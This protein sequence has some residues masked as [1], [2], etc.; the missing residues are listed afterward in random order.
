[1]PERISTRTYST[2]DVQGKDSWIKLRG[3]TL[4]EAINIRQE[5]EERAGF[6]FRLG[7]LLG[8]LFKKAPTQSEVAHRNT[9]W[10]FRFVRDWNWVDDQGEPLPKPEAD[11]DVRF[12]LTLEEMRCITDCVNGARGSEEQKN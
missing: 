4:G 12:R 2:E 9:E 10:A 8:R 1:M 3:M 5:A 6:W 7:A 11:P